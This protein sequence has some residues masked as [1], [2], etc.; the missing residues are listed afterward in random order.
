MSSLLTPDQSPDAGLRE[1]RVLLIVTGGIAATKAPDLV[2]RLRDRGA[3]VTCVLTRSGAEFTTAMAL[4]AV[5]ETEVYQDLFSLTD[6]QKMGHIR[7]ARD[8][9]VVLVAPTTADLMARTVHGRADDLASA[10][11]LATRAPVVMVPAMNPAMWANPATADNVRALSARGVRFVGPD[12]GLMACG[13]TGTGRMVE[14]AQIADWLYTFFMARTRLLGCRALV[15]SG[16]TF[17]ALDPVRFIANRSS[18]KQGHAIARA[19]SFM[20]ADTT[21]VSGPVALAPPDGVTVINVESA[22]DM[23]A[24]CNDVLT[25][26]K[27]IDV[28]I[29]A[30]AVAD[31]RAADVAPQ[32]IKK[33]ADAPNE[34]QDQAPA[35]RLA[36]NPDILKTV[37]EMGNRRP[38]L[39]VGFAAETENL[40]QNA[41]AKRARKKCDWILANDVSPGSETFGGDNTHVHFISARDSVDWGAMSKDAVAEKLGLHIAGALSGTSEKTVN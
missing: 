13:E 37:S 26:D 25:K 32:K 18:G 19:L 28:A 27:P 6:E 33:N 17:E 24:A 29:M 38:R 1:K 8:F 30:A 12:V 4:G 41:T 20:G 10:I 5:S 36:P 31:W 11:L 14:P 2:R 15:T 40:T 9:D 35:F 39:V 7:L 23:M 22:R 3:T 21:L 34:A 16:P